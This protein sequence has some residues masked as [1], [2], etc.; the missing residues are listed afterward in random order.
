MT[1]AVSR[2]IKTGPGLR[3]EDGLAV[4]LDM[5][6]PSRAPS[7]QHLE[8]LPNDRPLLFEPASVTR[9]ETSVIFR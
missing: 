7:R 4:A 1:S 9:R 5:L 3:G 8:P 6:I 2:P